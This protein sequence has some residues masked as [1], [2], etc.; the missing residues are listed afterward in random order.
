MPSSNIDSKSLAITPFEYS[1]ASKWEVDNKLTYSAASGQQSQVMSQLMDVRF[2]RD[3]VSS[4]INTQSQ[5]TMLVDKDGFACVPQK[6]KT[7]DRVRSN[8]DESHLPT[9]RI[10]TL[11]IPLIKKQTEV[12]IEETDPFFIDYEIEKYKRNTMKAAPSKA[13]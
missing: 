7:A 9:E 13:M 10:D 4:S 12:K 8:T 2:K 3:G 11:N 5:V 6:I 1:R